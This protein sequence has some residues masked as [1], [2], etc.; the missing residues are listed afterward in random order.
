MSHLCHSK[1][2]NLTFTFFREILADPDET[3]EVILEE[4]IT[5]IC[6]E[7]GQLC[8]VLKSGGSSSTRETFSTCLELAR[9]RYSVLSTIFKEASAANTN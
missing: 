5:I 7:E 1:F 4:R 9:N 3:E 8:S 6:D 2:Q